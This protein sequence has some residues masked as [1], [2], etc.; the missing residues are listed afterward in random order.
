MT[1]P[2]PAGFGPA[3]LA[4]C[5][6]RGVD[7]AAVAAAR[8][9][10]WDEGVAAAAVACRPVLAARLVE[11]R[12]TLAAAAA[13]GL[14]CWVL[15]RRGLRLIHSL[16]REDGAVWAHVSLSRADRVMPAWE[17]VRDVW[18]LLYPETAGVV[19]IPPAASHVDHAEVAHVWGN[20]DRPAVPDFS[21]G[22]GTI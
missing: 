1:G 12:W 17:Q 8:A 6:E 3:S 11:A 15:R 4:W 21:H 22:L 20:L 5:A 7:P 16:S 19:V 2:V 13:D 10:A 14:G 9:A 18:R